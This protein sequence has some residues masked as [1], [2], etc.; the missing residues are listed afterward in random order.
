M[1]LELESRANTNVV[2]TLCQ[3][4]VLVGIGPP[5]LA[6]LIGWSPLLVTSPGFVGPLTTQWVIGGKKLGPERHIDDDDDD[7]AVRNWIR[8]I[9]NAENQLP[10]S[11][12]Q[13]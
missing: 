12:P 8:Y 11:T 1:K 13:P 4:D 5:T 7:D 6:V 3:Y 10:T 9:Y 2:K